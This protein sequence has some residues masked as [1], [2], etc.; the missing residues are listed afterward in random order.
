[1]IL[2]DIVQIWEAQVPLGEAG[3]GCQ[4]VRRTIDV[5]STCS[6]ILKWQNPVKG[7]I[8]VDKPGLTGKVL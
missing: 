1:M 8:Y 3:K 4:T 5:F 6:V 7:L 2:I